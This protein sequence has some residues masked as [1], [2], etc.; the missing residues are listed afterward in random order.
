MKI[1]VAIAALGT[2]FLAGCQTT[3]EALYAAGVKQKLIVVVPPES[4]YQCPGK[5]AR[6]NPDTLTDKQTAKYLVRIDAAHTKCFNSVAAV[7]DYIG[8]AKARIEADNR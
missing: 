8:K 4:L 3:D 2:L 7:K 6:P 1:A 5:P